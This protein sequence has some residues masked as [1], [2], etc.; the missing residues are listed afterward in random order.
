[1]A[2]IEFYITGAA[3]LFTAGAVAG[4]LALVT[5]G[6]RREERDYSMTIEAPNK[7]ARGARVVNGMHARQPGVLY[8]AAYYKRP[9]PAQVDHD[10]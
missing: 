7:I 4:F 9:Q 5:L 10:W 2:M 6:I 8:E 1:M 3:V